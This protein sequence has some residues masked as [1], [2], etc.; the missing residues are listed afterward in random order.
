M[1]LFTPKIKNISPVG[2]G[3][4]VFKLCFNFMFTFQVINSEEDNEDQVIDSEK[5]D[6]ELD[7]PPGLP[8]SIPFHS[9]FNM[10]VL[11]HFHTLYRTENIDIKM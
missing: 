8:V 1:C 9:C 4:E 6:E 7:P 10:D 3:I 2:I 11:V 5:E